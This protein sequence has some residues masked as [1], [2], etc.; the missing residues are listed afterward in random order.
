[1]ADKI[2]RPAQVECD[3]RE[4]TAYE[5]HMGRTE[6]SGGDPMQTIRHDDG[7]EEEGCRVGNVWGSYLNGWLK[8]RSFDVGWQLR[9]VGNVIRR[10]P[11]PGWN[12][13]VR[14]TMRWPITWGEHVN[15]TSV[16][17]YLEL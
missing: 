2:V 14:L 3:G 11:C 13:A 4:W 9:P 17:R 12:A 16:R 5:I 1:M 7:T 8:R 15:L 10:T 6:R